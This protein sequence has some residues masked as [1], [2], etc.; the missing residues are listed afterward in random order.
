MNKLQ[1]RIA[2]LL[3][4]LNQGIYEKENETALALLAALAGESILL[5]GP[6][7]V[8]KSMVAR[9]MRYGKRVRLYRTVC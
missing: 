2:S 6:P 1:Q 9:W 5:L 7:G 8:A 3:K 4:S